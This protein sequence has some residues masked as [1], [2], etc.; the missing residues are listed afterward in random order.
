M[1]DS[2]R[3]YRQIHT[4]FYFNAIVSV[5]I[6]DVNALV[7]QTGAFDFPLNPPKSTLSFYCDGEI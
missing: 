6:H 7:Q 2:R 4:G 5:P 1:L 3:F